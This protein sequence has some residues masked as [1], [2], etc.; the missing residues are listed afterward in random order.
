[1]CGT[2]EQLRGVFLKSDQVMEGV[3]PVEGAG[4]YE[5]HEQIPNVGP[6]LSF[7][8]EAALAM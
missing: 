8:E 1:M 6:V 7:E 3:E 5:T 2:F 4:M